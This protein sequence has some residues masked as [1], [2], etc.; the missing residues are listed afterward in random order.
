MMPQPPAGVFFLLFFFF[1]HRH[2]N[3]EHDSKHG[4]TKFIRSS[5][6]FSIAF[7]SNAHFLLLLFLYPFL[8]G[9]AAIKQMWSV[10]PCGI[11][12]YQTAPPVV[13]K[14]RT[15]RILSK[16]ELYSETLISCLSS[17]PVTNES[18]CIS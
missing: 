7:S 8:P 17:R 1:K 6:S 15:R 2:T 11:A 18:I 9:G 4:E 10:I 13:I 12:R 16:D 5:A 3:Q 14:Q